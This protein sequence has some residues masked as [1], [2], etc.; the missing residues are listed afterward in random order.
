MDATDTITDQPADQPADV[1]RPRIRAIM[2][3]EERTQADLAREADIPNGTF[4]LWFN[5]KYAGNN[6]LVAAKVEKWLDAREQHRAMA[7]VMPA[8]PQF[9]R[10]PTSS[11]ILPDLVFAQVMPAFVAIVGAAGVGKTR[12]AQYHQATNPHVWIV[13]AE[14][15]VRRTND[16]LVA[17]CHVL[18]IQEKRAA[19][20]S[21]AI[22]ARI[23]GTGGLLILD[24]AQEA[25]VAAL[26][27]L[28]VLQD[29]YEIG[30]A[31]IG[32]ETIL[33]NLGY[34]DRSRENLTSRVG[35][36][37]IIRGASAGDADALLDAW[38]IA[39]AEERRFLNGVAVK[40]GALR[41]MSWCL[42]QAH[43]LAAGCGEP[44]AL[45]H[46]RAAAKDLC[47]IPSGI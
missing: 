6:A 33:A 36:K 32:N 12:T 47:T 10:T 24:E 17:F 28:R 23:K 44:V 16:I 26:Q 34:G 31:L 37:P 4:N 9:V 43:I 11:R 13:T 5:G 25:E 7:S 29:L 42:K 20:L 1:L 14:P 27:Q 21:A 38:G 8:V 35:K 41:T 46:L 19:R 30:V 15:S 3:G 18:G 40:T 22:G 39:G 45:K 2:A